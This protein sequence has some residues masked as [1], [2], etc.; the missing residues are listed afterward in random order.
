M[1]KDFNQTMEPSLKF[2]IGL[3]AISVVSVFYFLQ[4]LHGRSE[5]YDA[6]D[7]IQKWSHIRKSYLTQED[8]AL[9]AANS[10]DKAKNTKPV[11]FLDPTKRH[12]GQ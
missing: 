9:K 8:A 3:T 11:S 4:W 12:K 1:H 5:D 2:L 7:L 10:T 6:D